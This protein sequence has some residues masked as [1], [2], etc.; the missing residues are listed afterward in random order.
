MHI[1][2]MAFEGSELGWISYWCVCVYIYFE[3]IRFYQ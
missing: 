1:L 2:E 3:V